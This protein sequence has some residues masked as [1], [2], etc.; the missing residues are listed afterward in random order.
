MAAAA[1]QL[2]VS[3]IKIMAAGA[4]QPGGW[5]VGSGQGVVQATDLAKDEQQQGIQ[6]PVETEGTER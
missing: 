3:N 6:G 4:K 2:W 5:K 1:A